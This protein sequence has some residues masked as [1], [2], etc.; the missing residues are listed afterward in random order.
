MAAQALRLSH[1]GTECP[2]DSSLYQEV[3]E[4]GTLRQASTDE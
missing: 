3:L 2:S 4:N 1:L